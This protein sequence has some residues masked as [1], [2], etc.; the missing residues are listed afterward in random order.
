MP[1]TESLQLLRL[2]LSGDEGAYRRD[3]VRAAGTGFVVLFCTVGIAL[4]GLPFYYDFMTQQYGWTRAQ[5]TSGNAIGKLVVG[6]LFGFLAGWIVDRYGPRRMM[7]A[8]I[9]MAGTALVGLGTF[10]SLSM[11]YLFYL[12]NAFGYVCGGPIPNQ[13]LLSQWFKRS[14]G[15]AVGF[16]Y[17]GIGAGGACAPWISHMLAE[18]FGWQMSL[19]ILGVFIVV[20]A[21]PFVLLLKELPRSGIG[22][23]AERRVDARVAFRSTAFY[24]LTLGSMCSIA[25]VSATQQNLKFVLSLDRHFTQAETVQ[26]LSLVLAVSIP[27]RL[28]VGWLADRYSKKY[29]MLTIY[30]LVAVAAP[31]LFLGKSHTV[32]LGF[33]V[34]FGIALG[35]EY[36][37]L[38]L[39]TA[40]IFGVRVLGRLMGVIVT[41][42]GVAEAVAPW[43]L[44]RLRDSAISDVGLC[45]ALS[46]V[47]MVGAAAVLALPKGQTTICGDDSAAAVQS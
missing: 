34:L 27:G 32:V 23:L 38:P 28:L 25:V 44:N 33:A 16:A 29:V 24:L 36:M 41:A 18:R 12:F 11:F 6:P 2:S 8:G 3:Q 21:M 9:L 7:M 43:L 15:K 20:A 17:L 37:L 14:R 19:R 31:G 4:W 46:G 35:A 13:V 39:M 40:E 47:A 45:A 1:N 5:V 30:L 26:V 10:S 22:Q 42:G